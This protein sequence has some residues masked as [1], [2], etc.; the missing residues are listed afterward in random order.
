MW[1]WPPLMQKELDRFRKSANSRKV[2][3]QKDKVLPSGVSPNIAYTLP[4]KYNGEECLQPVDV[5]LIDAILADMQ[6]QKDALSDWG[7]PEEFDRRAQDAFDR[8]PI[9]EVTLQTI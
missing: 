7:V 5:D 9:R 8:L 4:E 1:L 2:Q 3:K 6:P